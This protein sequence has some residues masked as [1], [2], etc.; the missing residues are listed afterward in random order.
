MYF[1]CHPVWFIGGISLGR[2]RLELD[3]A[4]GRCGNLLNSLGP[5]V[6]MFSLYSV[7]HTLEPA[8]SL[9]MKLI[10]VSNTVIHYHFLNLLLIL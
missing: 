3:W 6:L 8:I 2:F 7:S 4:L 9:D 10:L 5:F 1:I